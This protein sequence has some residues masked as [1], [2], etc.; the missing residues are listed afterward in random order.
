MQLRKNLGL[1]WMSVSVSVSVPISISN[2][3]KSY[4]R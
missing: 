4:G 2:E 1:N 3:T